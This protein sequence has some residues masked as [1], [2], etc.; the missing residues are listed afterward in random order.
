MSIEED[1][2]DLREARR[3]RM[4]HMFNVLADSYAGSP[5]AIAAAKQHFRD[6]LRFTRE[7][8]AFAAAEIKAE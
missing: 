2:D 1:L 8:T 4:D 7:A 6:G 3:S 5:N